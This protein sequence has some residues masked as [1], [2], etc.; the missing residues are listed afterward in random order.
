MSFNI[1]LSNKATKSPMRLS[2]SALRN[3]MI[4]GGPGIAGGGGGGG[5]A[6]SGFPNKPV[7]YTNSIDFNCSQNP[8]QSPPAN[9]QVDNPIPGGNGWN[10][11][12]FGTSYQKVT[13]STDPQS[14]S[15]VWRLFWPSATGTI[16]Q[17]GGRGIGNMFITIGTTNRMYLCVHILFEPGYV[18]H[19]ISNKFINIENSN[20]LY[21]VQLREGSYWLHCEQLGFAGENFYIDPENTA[22][23]VN[24]TAITVGDWHRIEM[25][26]ETGNGAAGAGTWKTWLDGTIQT[27]ASGLTFRNA[28]MTG[29]GLNAFRGGGEEDGTVPDMYWRYGNIH[30]AW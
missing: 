2:P 30:L 12:Y 25:V 7:S 5:G 11:I 3:S 19:P 13:D 21:L 29:L 24:N 14:P 1:I 20:S 16:G 23:Q 6:L 15:D 18:W 8:V 22:G 4:A 17:G 26:I 9:D 28:N 27:N 10:M